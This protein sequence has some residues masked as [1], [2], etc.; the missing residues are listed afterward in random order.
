[1]NT[2]Y[3]PSDD[4]QVE[5]VAQDAQASSQENQFEA[6]VVPVETLVNAMQSV[7]TTSEEAQLNAMSMDD[8]NGGRIEFNED[9]SST[10]HIK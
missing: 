4:N 6:P 10:N 3:N 1:M 2:D 9:S 5:I 7:D 8:N